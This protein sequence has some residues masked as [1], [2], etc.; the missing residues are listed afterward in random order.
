M[1]SSSLRFSAV[2]FGRGLPLFSAVFFSHFLG[3][4]RFVSYLSVMVQSVISSFFASASSVA[5]S[6]SRSQCLPFFVSRLVFS[7]VSF[8]SPVLVGCAAGF[9][10]S[11]RLAFPSASVFSVSS[12]GSGRGAF[13]R[14]SSAMVSAVASVPGGVLFSAPG[15][16]CP[17]GLRPSASS[18]ACFCGLGSGS[19]AGVALGVG[20]GVPV[21]VWLPPGVSA[22][23]SFGF[24]SLGGGFFVSRPVQASLF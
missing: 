20:L 5:F 16:P 17:S 7:S 12:F 3:F 18:S 24:V 1:R 14:R 2:A 21:L 22:P 13:A 4:Q 11:V 10:A 15:S 6:G 19:W 9:D 23:S 8:S